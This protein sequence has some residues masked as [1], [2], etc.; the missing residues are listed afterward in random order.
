MIFLLATPQGATIFRVLMRLHWNEALEQE[1]VRICV[2][3][4]GI[5]SKLLFG[6]VSEKT[7]K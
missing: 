3:D 4:P 6:S 7:T 1:F 5:P 2:G